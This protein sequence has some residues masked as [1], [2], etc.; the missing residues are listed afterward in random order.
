MLKNHNS[1][2]PPGRVLA[3]VLAALVSQV[4]CNEHTFRRVVATT[5]RTVVT[6]V[7]IDIDRAADILFV[8]DN[9]GSMAEEQENLARNASSSSSSSPNNL[10]DASGYA[11][12]RSYLDANPG[13]AQEQYEP[14]YKAIFE[15]CGFIER[16]QLFKNHFHIGVISTDM[17]NCDRPGSTASRAS[18]PQLGCLQASAQD[19]NLTVL[20]WETP[21]LANKFANIIRNIGVYGS[22][23]EQGLGSAENFLTAGHPVADS[24]QCGAS[25]RD[26]SADLTNFL[27]ETAPNASGDEVATKLVVVFM[28][29]EE[30]CSNAN[31]IDETVPGNTSLCYTNPELLTNTEHFVNFFK[32][33]KDKSELVSMGLIAGLYDDGTG[34]IPEGCKEAASGDATN[35]CDPAQGNSVAT[36][37]MCVNG[38]PICACHPHIDAADCQ[39]AEQPATNCCQADPA[40]RYNKVVKQMYSFKT[41]TLCRSSY[42]DTMISIANLVNQSGTVVLPEPPADASQLVVKMRGPG[43]EDGVT[44]LNVPRFDE[45]TGE[46]GEGGWTLIDDNTVIKFFRTWVPQPGDEVQVLYLGNIAD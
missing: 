21:D 30:D 24:S 29:D 28:T 43:R 32:R 11:N 18:V 22:P 3:L 45:A 4:A 35:A 23:Y 26:C 36:C 19:P 31:A 27:R 34:M 44:W 10:C 40:T 13:L 5:T 6:G 1:W 14:S 7:N 9:S 8:I 25:Q 46:P 38:E 33:V 42:K 17:N 37:N 41:D 12:L 2:I 20:T 39:G 16:L 15:Q